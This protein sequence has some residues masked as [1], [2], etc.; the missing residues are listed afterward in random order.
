MRLGGSVDDAGTRHLELAEEALG[1]AD[2][3]GV[4]EHLSAAIRSFTAGGDNRRA[5]MACVRLGDAYAH[6]VGNLTA[7]RVWFRRAV[8]LLEDEPP[9]LEQ[10]WVAVAA[11]GCDVDDPAELLARAELALDRAR[12]FGDV[13]LEAKA[14]ADAGLAEVQAGRLE[15]GMALLDESMALTCG[16]VDDVE[17]AGKSVCSFF[18]A[19]YY[20]GDF[21]RAG[22]WADGLRRQG[23][24]G[25]TAVMPVFLGNHCDAV[26]ATALCELGRWGEAETLLT[27][28]IVAFERVMP[29]PSWHPAIALAELRIRQ[30]RLADAEALLLGRDGHLQALLPAARLHLA[31][32]DLDLARA[33]A[34]RGLRAV[35]DDR[36]RGAELLAVV[37]DVEVMAG[38]LDAAAAA[39]DELVAR[40]GSLD[41]PVL[42]ARAAASCA[43][44]AAARGD[45]DEAVT[46][47]EAALDALPPT[48]LPLLRGT[49]LVDLVRLLVQ[50][51]DRP[52][53]TVAG[54]SAVATLQ[55]LDMVLPAADVAVLADVGADLPAHPT[56][57][58]VVATLRRDELGWVTAADGMQARLRDTKGVRYLAELVANPGIERHALDLVD[59]VEGVPSGDGAAVD[60][61]RL[62]DAGPQVDARARQA[63]RRR[64]EE[65]RTEVQDALELGAEDRAEALQAE[66]DALVG[67]L[68]RAFG[69]GGRT[70]VSASAAER[71]RVNV[72]RSLR[73]ATARIREVLPGPGAM[74][75]QRLRTGLYCAYEP[76]ADDDV[77][78]SVQS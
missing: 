52:A 70:R 46:T 51:G 54:R 30:G 29:T 20:A 19:C 35:R 77:R 57:P 64:I 45:L 78:W 4:L 47:L 40:L 34:R 69:L 73:T 48:G 3:D 58:P 50:A 11:L 7:A 60:R 76:D 55:G 24:I 53:A 61:R 17:S 41:V 38:D 18:T 59:H 32:G 26:Q 31:R 2:V 49:L 65:L 72:T 68:A 23:L 5:A 22:S 74:L 56:A 10:G 44:L 12:R 8:R 25:T 27:N 15:E 66:L 14:L 16:P 39:C 67:E 62:G 36:L 21:D 75:D 42:R 63:Y 6:T 37:V 43:R 1:A 28:A 71:A 33:A 13:N 9:C